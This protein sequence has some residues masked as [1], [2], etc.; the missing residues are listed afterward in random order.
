MRALLVAVFASLLAVPAQAAQVTLA[1][2]PNP[3]AENVVAYRVWSCP[4]GLVTGCTQVAETADT[5]ITVDLRPWTHFLR[6]TA[7]NAV[8]MSSM[9]SN[10]LVAH[11]ARERRNSFGAGTFS[12]SMR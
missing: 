10:E 5:T 8:G 1:W 9:F 7:V 3:P 11:F 12:G 2:D 6:A 4:A